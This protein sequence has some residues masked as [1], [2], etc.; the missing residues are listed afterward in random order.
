V[1]DR[2]MPFDFPTSPTVGQAANG[3]QWDGE[4]WTG[5]AGPAAPVTEQFFTLDGLA[6]IDITVPTWAKSC[7]LTGVTRPVTANAQLYLQYSLDGTNFI[8]GAATY[9]MYGPILN[10]GSTGYQAFGFQD[11]NG[12]WL[13]VQGD[14]NL[15]PHIFEATVDLTRPSNSVTFGVKIDSRMVDSAGTSGGRSLPN[16]AVMKTASGTGLKVQKMRLSMGAGNFGVGSWVKVKWLGE[17]AQIPTGNAIPD[18]PSDGGE[19]VRVNGVWRL[20]RQT[21]DLAGVINAD[22]AVPAGAKRVRWE[23]HAIASSATNQHMGFRVSIDGTNFLSGA[24]DYTYAG[25]A[26][27]TTINPTQVLNYPAANANYTFLSL[28]QN[29]ATVNHI[30]DGTIALTRATTSIIFAGRAHAHSY[31]TSNGYQT[32]DV[33][34]WVNVANLGSALALQRLR[35]FNVGAVVWAQGTINFEWMY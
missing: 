9:S 19:Y 15:I 25:Y 3:Y 24:S 21:V 1:E 12:I 28:A 34:H 14:N 33:Q 30:F 5:G 31:Q 13:T 26:H 2:L 11:T 10:A 7:V 18:A 17:S 20:A 4:K 32:L 23:G 8:Q 35:F 6:L 27:L 29:D 16:M 22:V